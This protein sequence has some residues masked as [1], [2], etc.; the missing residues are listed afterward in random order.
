M[1]SMGGLAGHAGDEAGARQASDL[2]CVPGAGFAERKLTDLDTFGDQF[3]RLA[4]FE[5]GMVW[6]S[7]VIWRASISR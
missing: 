4:E 1:T 5:G 7:S 3:F 6:R 2:R